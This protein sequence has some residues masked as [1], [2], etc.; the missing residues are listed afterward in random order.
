MLPVDDLCRVEQ[1]EIKFRAVTSKHIVNKI[2][3]LRVGKAAGPDN[4][5]TTVV[6]DVGGIVAKPL[7]MIVNSS[8]SQAHAADFYCCD[9]RFLFFPV[10]AHSRLLSLLKTISEVLLRETLL[11]GCVGIIFQANSLFFYWLSKSR[12][13]RFLSRNTAHSRLLSLVS[14]DQ[15]QISSMLDLKTQSLAIKIV[16]HKLPHTADFLD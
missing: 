13:P 16:S 15:K 9:I 5:P 8:L 11:Q 12:G 3:K 7:A 10:A 2:K 14:C 1:K 4:I 6:K